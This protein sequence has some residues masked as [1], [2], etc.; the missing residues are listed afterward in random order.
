MSNTKFALLR[1]LA[2]EKK[3]KKKKT[4]THSCQVNASAAIEHDD[5]AQI[6]IIANQRFIGIDQIFISSDWLDLRV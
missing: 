1:R 5:R 2:R 6:M 3:K 4:E